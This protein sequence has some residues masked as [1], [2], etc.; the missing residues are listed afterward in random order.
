MGHCHERGLGL[1]AGVDQLGPVVQYQLHHLVVS[2][3]YGLIQ[4]GRHAVDS[5]QE[6]EPRLVDGP[7]QAALH[8][9]RIAAGR[10]LDDVVVQRVHGLLAADLQLAGV[11]GPHEALA[12]VDHDLVLAVHV[13]HLPGASRDVVQGRVF[14]VE[15]GP[16]LPAVRHGSLVANTPALD[17][18]E[19]GRV[20][21]PP[22]SRR[23]GESCGRG[24]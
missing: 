17:Q 22:A 1:V 5:R 8:A 15:P 12:K 13:G 23:G 2:V 21:G 11:D 24:C 10:V 4:L 7:R 6:D 3:P 18:A 19:D 14:L 16:H 9:R 20:D